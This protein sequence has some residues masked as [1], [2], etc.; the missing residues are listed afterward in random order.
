[1]PEPANDAETE[2]ALEPLPPARLSARDRERLRRLPRSR[3]VWEGDL[4]DL[5]IE[6]ERL[7]APLCALWADGDGTI[8]AMVP[9]VSAEPGQLVLVAFIRAA[10]RPQ[11]GRAEVPERVRVHP[12]TASALR[13][14]LGEVGVVVEE[15]NDLPLA[16]EALESLAEFLAR[17]SGSRQRRRRRRGH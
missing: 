13:G 11:T 3:H 2:D 5:P 10:L 4:T 12:E 1:M 16:H 8:R 14:T 17:S 6:V 9:D 15:A 7:G